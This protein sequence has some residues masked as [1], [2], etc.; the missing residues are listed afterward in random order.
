MNWGHMKKAAFIISIFMLLMS[1]SVYALGVHAADNSF[2]DI[3]NKF[4]EESKEIKA[5][6]PS[7]KD[8]LLLSS[9]WDTCLLT[10][11]ELDAYFHMLG[12]FNTIKEKDLSEDAVNYLAKWLTEIKRNNELNIGILNSGSYSF[13]PGTRVHIEGLKSYLDELNK[14]IDTELDK[15]SILNKSIRRKKK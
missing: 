9:M 10:M 7:S 8:A 1:F 5:L 3:R 6:L 4:F 2:L 15:I 11:S 14:R 13:E 12:I